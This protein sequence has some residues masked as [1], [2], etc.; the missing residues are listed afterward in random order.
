[1]AMAEG[2]KKKA[3]KKVAP[4]PFEDDEDDEQPDPED[5]ADDEDDED[6]DEE[7]EEEEV[8]TGFAPWVVSEEQEWELEELLQDADAGETHIFYVPPDPKKKTGAKWYKLMPITVG[9]LMGEVTG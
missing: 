3:K 7:F 4:E 6:E 8:E 9:E 1:M 5:V 2:N